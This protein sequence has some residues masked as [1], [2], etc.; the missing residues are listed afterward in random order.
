ME[1][2]F[3]ALTKVLLA[4]MAGNQSGSC[5]VVKFAHDDG[6]SPDKVVIPLVVAAERKNSPAVAN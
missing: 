2:N 4:F 5:E 3:S 1:A 6:I